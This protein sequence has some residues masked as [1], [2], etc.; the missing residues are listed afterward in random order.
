VREVETYGAWAGGVFHGEG[1]HR[2]KEMIHFEVEGYGGGNRQKHVTKHPKVER[3][4]SK[5]TVRLL[6]VG[7]RQEIAGAEPASKVTSYGA[8]IKSLGFMTADP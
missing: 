5:L 3:N 1:I 4:D 8:M 6:R 7:S 2:W